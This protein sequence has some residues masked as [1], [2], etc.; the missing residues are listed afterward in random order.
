MQEAIKMEEYFEHEYQRRVTGFVDVDFTKHIPSILGESYEQQYYRPVESWKLALKALTSTESRDIVHDVVPQIGVPEDVEMLH[1]LTK[2]KTRSFLD[3]STAE[4]IVFLHW[5]CYSF[6]DTDFVHNELNT[7]AQAPKQPTPLKQLVAQFSALLT[8]DAGDSDGAMN[9]DEILAEDDA[10]E[11]ITRDS[12]KK[13][14]SS[15]SASTSMA[16]MQSLD[17]SDKTPSKWSKKRPREADETEPE[18]EDSAKSASSVKK[19]LRTSLPT[20]GSD[21]GA[22]KMKKLEE[23]PIADPVMVH[24]HDCL[25]CDRFGNRFWVFSDHCTHIPTLF[26]EVRFQVGV[27]TVEYKV[28]QPNAPNW[29]L[30]SNPQ[31]IWKLVCWLDERGVSEAMLLRRIYE[32]VR[33]NAIELPK[34]DI[35]TE[36]YPRNIVETCKPTGK[37]RSE[38]RLAYELISNWRKLN[39]TCDSST[40]LNNSVV[41]SSE[42]IRLRAHHFMPVTKQTTRFFVLH[43]QFSA[44]AKQ[45]G[46]GVKAAPDGAVYVTSFATAES[47]TKKAGF[48]VGDRII[49]AGARLRPNVSALVDLVKKASFDIDQDPSGKVSRRLSFIVRRMEV[50]VEDPMFRAITEKDPDIIKQCNQQNNERE[51]ELR[52]LEQDFL[53]NSNDKGSFV[54]LHSFSSKMKEQPGCFNEVLTMFMELWLKLAHPA[55]TTQY[56]RATLLEGWLAKL[57]EVISDSQ[58]SS[59]DSHSTEKIREGGSWLCQYVA[60]AMLDLEWD[61]Y[62]VGSVLRDDWLGSQIGFEGDMTSPSSISGSGLAS[63]VASS[64][65]N[66]S[67]TFVP[68]R[69]AVQQCHSR[70]RQQW[71]Q[72]CRSGV[73]NVE[74]WSYA[75]ATFMY[76]AVDWELFQRHLIPVPADRVSHV[77]QQVGMEEDFVGHMLKEGN[78]LVYFGDGH[79]EANR[80]DRDLYAPSHQQYFHTLADQYFRRPYLQGK[81][82]ATGVGRLLPF[83][84]S[85]VLWGDSL[86]PQEGSVLLCQIAKALVYHT[87]IPFVQLTL[88]ILSPATQN[89]Q[90]F[91]T[92]GDVLPI[93]NQRIALSRHLWRI[94]QFVKR[95]N[96]CKPF[97]TPVSPDEYPT[98]CEVVQQP[99]DLGI[100]E[101]KIIAQQYS[102]HAQFLDDMQLLYQNCSDFCGADSKRFP[103]LARALLRDA[104]RLCRKY[105]ETNYVEGSDAVEN[106]QQ[107]DADGLDALGGTYGEEEDR[108]DAKDV[109]MVVVD[110]TVSQTQSPTPS[111]SMSPMRRS[112]RLTTGSASSSN[113]HLNSGSDN[114]LAEDY[115]DK[116]S[117]ATPANGNLHHIGG[118][119]AVIPTSMTPQASFKSMVITVRLDRLWPTFLVE[120]DVYTRCLKRWNAG[121]ITANRSTVRVEIAPDKQGNPRY[122]TGV[123]VGN[124]E[125]VVVSS[126]NNSSA[127]VMPWEFIQV[128]W[129]EP[130]DAILMPSHVN[131]WDVDVIPDK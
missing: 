1:V 113:S 40:S 3:L 42:E 9:I 46:M 6:M 61:L 57:L 10:E 21:K 93:P 52:V 7:K 60:R 117:A 39:Y 95:N 32:W 121:M 101:K 97:L 131:C 25:G 44:Q 105:F 88:T 58:S 122:A 128:D 83:R 130:A 30:F 8:E 78:R 2:L 120:Q 36:I 68:G 55:F 43:V 110:D 102:H 41:L 123:I 5:L 104:Q 64:G 81:A 47:V 67:A 89:N 20:N 115:K 119:A 16:S 99:I 85:T 31:D 98:Y 50:P 59:S 82:Q 129:T 15:L 90:T 86:P 76:H 45:L 77:L 38:E 108:D 124:K 34:S 118:T 127:R 79:A 14:N 109:S 87:T 100:I 66:N 26:C 22:D 103:P 51:Q 49:F 56:F 62:R 75:V 13:A 23:K 91:P 126:R 116:E 4:K 17:G 112:G 33:E 71:R 48:C 94:L 125:P 84:R 54:K 63:G 74:T 19:K 29:V 18:M 35:L 92:P 96:A 111:I 73:H 24:R 37:R 106:S 27:P 65:V 53:S 11:T 72:F 69:V 107:D 114:V 28:I 70:K 12:A 80:A